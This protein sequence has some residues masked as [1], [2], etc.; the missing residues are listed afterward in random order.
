MKPRS[1]RVPVNLPIVIEHG[2]ERFDAVA[3]NLGLGGVF[4]QA[5]P[6]L[7]YGEA[8]ELLVQ[9]P[10]LAGPSR[11]PGVVRWG[12]LGGIGVQFQQ[13]G[14]RETHAIGAAVAAYRAAELAASERSASA[15]GARPSA[16]P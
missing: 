1:L 2:R 4:V 9:L 12:N 6:A 8:L 15:A 14:A 11:L 5:C 13:L 16:P 10:G 3:V 7:P